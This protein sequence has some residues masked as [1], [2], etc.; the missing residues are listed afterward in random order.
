MEIYVCLLFQGSGPARSESASFS[1]TLASSR[2]TRGPGGLLSGFRGG[3]SPSGY[4]WAYSRK[5]SHF[6]SSLIL[7]TMCSSASFEL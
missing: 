1:A 7:A 6:Q 4:S 2:V 5:G 3:H